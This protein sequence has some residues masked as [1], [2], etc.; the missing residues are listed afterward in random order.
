MDTYIYTHTNFLY[1]VCVNVCVLEGAGGESG[2]IHPPTHS[3]SNTQSHTHTYIYIHRFDWYKYVVAVTAQNQAKFWYYKRFA[4]PW[5]ISNHRYIHFVDSDAGSPPEHPFDL[6]VYEQ[7]LWE[8]DLM[9]A[10][11]AVSLVGQPS[12]HKVCM[13]VRAFGVC[14]CR[15]LSMQ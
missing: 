2:C 14:V 12:D 13:C 9:I 1:C 8:R 3:F 10:Q 4:S 7:F 6:S 15:S 5:L 11:P